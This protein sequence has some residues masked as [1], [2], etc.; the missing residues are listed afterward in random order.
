MCVCVCARGVCMC[1]REFVCC[2]HN[3]SFSAYDAMCY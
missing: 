3:I 1:I 2:F